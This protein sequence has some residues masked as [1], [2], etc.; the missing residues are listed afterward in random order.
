MIKQ[1]LTGFFLF[2]V[3]GLAAQ[4]TTRIEIRVYPTFISADSNIYIAGSFNGW[5][6]KD[7]K[8]KFSRN[9]KGKYTIE[10]K[11]NAGNY[12][13]KVTRGGWDKVECKKDGTSINNR[14]LVVPAGQP[15]EIDIEEWQDNIASRPKPSTASRHLEIVSSSFYIPQ[16][17]RTRR[18]WIYLPENYAL[19]KKRYPVL[20]MHDGQNL[21]DDSIAFHGE[22]GVDE[23][24]DTTKTRENIVIAIDNDNEKRINEYSPY[25]FKLRDNEPKQRGEGAAYL[26]FIVKTLKPFIDKKYRTLKDPGNTFI[27]GSSMG[28]L[29]S[30]YAVIKYPKVFGGAGIFSPSIW[31]TK[32]ELL[33][34]IRSAGKKVHAKL[35]FYCGKMEADFMV[36]DMLKVFETLR[37]VS[38]TK[39]ITVIRDEG[40]HNEAT[41]RREF[42]LFYK[43]INSN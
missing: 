21:F 43:W 31:L 40:K 32:P 29:I 28:G 8:Y 36:P 25:D 3:S 34:Y 12:E 30:L 19:S 5:N 7:E 17:K 41:W 2:I 35:Y 37:S 10:L 15:F 33:S 39:M 38:K 14:Q 9:G 18:I 11:L 42:P 6:P 13:Y 16:L 27:A 1:V 20:Y 24:L 23:F 22:W 26:D 4:E